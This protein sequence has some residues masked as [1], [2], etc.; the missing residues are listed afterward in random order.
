[1]MSWTHCFFKI[2]SINDNCR[3]GNYS[4]DLSVNAGV[5][6]EMPGLNK[7]RT[8]D[9]MTRSITSRKLSVHTIKERARKVVE[10]VKRA[11][12]EAPEVK[13]NLQYIKPAHC[14]ACSGLGRGRDGTHGFESRRDGTHA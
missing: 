10:L 6:L 3:F 9:L 14:L 2:Q 1:M 13:S 4:V 5:D 11:A 8:P 7:W 12:Q